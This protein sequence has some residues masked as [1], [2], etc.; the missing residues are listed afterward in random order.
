MDRMN[1]EQWNESKRSNKSYESH[2]THLTFMTN[3]T[4]IVTFKRQRPETGALLTYNHYIPT[5]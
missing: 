5:I 2:M 1:P 3:L 4:L